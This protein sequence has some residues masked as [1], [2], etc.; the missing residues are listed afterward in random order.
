MLVFATS[1]NLRCYPYSLKVGGVGGVCALLFFFAMTL[2]ASVEVARRSKIS[3][4]DRSFDVALDECNFHV[5]ENPR[6]RTEQLKPLYNSLQV[7]SSC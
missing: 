6:S 4:Q 1:N 5:E 7:I 3:V 2:N